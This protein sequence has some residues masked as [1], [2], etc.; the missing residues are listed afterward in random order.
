MLSGDPCWRRKML[1][2]TIES[3]ARN[4]LCQFWKDWNQNSE[5]ERKAPRFWG[6]SPCSVRFLVK[7]VEPA[8]GVDGEAAEEKEEEGEGQRIAIEPTRA[9]LGSL[10]AFAVFF[11]LVGIEGFGGA[12]LIEEGGEPDIE[13]HL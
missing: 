10:I 2:T 1:S 7:F 6:G 9:G 4:S 11:F 5:S 3:T 13:S 12:P 8:G